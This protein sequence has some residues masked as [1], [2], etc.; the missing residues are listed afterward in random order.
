MPFPCLGRSQGVVTPKG[1]EGA[2]GLPEIVVSTK[3]YVEEAQNFP[4]QNNDNLAHRNI[5]DTATYLRPDKQPVEPT[6][7]NRSQ[8]AFQM[9]MPISALPSICRHFFNA[10]T[11][12]QAIDFPDRVGE[13]VGIKKLTE[14]RETPAICHLGDRHL[15]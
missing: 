7:W 11:A 9:V 5:S 4:L 8:T 10:D 14:S 1:E 2:D 12:A 15:R 6:Q 3:G 13:L